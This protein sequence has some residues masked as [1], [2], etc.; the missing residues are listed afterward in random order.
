MS[1]K[2]YFDYNYELIASLLYGL[3]YVFYAPSDGNYS[4][5][6]TKDVDA[7]TEEKQFEYTS[8]LMGL[9]SVSTL[10]NAIFKLTRFY[11]NHRFLVTDATLFSLNEF[12]HTN[13]LLPAS[14]EWANSSDGFVHLFGY[15][16][17]SYAK[18]G[19]Y[20]LDQKE[21]FETIERITRFTHSNMRV[22]IS[23][24]IFFAIMVKLLEAR[25]KKNG[26]ALSSKE[27]ASCIDLGIRKVLYHY[28]DYQYIGEL[29]Y[30][31]RLD[32]QLYDHATTIVPSSQI[33]KINPKELRA[34]NYVVDSIETLIYSLLVAKS[35]EEGIA[36]ISAIPAFH[37]NNLFL[38]T[39]VYALAHRLPAAITKTYPHNRMTDSDALKVY[40]ESDYKR[41]F[42]PIKA[43][44]G[45]MVNEGKL[46]VEQMNH[47]VNQLSFEYTRLGFEIKPPIVRLFSHPKTSQEAYYDLYVLLKTTKHYDQA[48][49]R[50]LALIN[51]IIN[52]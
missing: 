45:L 31:V 7:Q 4:K 6:M 49:F 5:L 25:V 52:V 47:Y 2:I 27:M 15:M 48:F 30:F 9:N 16:L 51:N 22:I 19:K 40:L 12:V 33:V 1:K 17:S 8:L 14:G 28:R 35:Y 11:R 23:H 13:T 3:R 26:R 50:Q 10:E 41:A 39:I 34:G 18:Q 43:I 24:T 44:V 38:F 20:V 32:K 21:T 29:R 36:M 46:Q 42:K 37:P